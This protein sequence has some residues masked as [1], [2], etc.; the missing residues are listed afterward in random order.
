MTILRKPVI[1]NDPG[2]V[3]V[4]LEAMKNTLILIGVNQQQIVLTGDRDAERSGLSCMKDT[5]S[6]KIGRPTSRSA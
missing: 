5:A 2:L 6:E 4:D 3:A 1:H